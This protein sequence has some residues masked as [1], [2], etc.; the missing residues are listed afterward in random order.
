MERAELVARLDGH[1]WSDIEFKQ[2]Q[3]GVPDSAYETVSAFSN[4]KGGWLVFGVRDGKGGVEIVGVLDADKVQNDFL[5]TL[6][7]GQKLNR[8]VAAEERAIED[9]GKTLL[10][11]HIPEADRRD[12]PVYLGRDIRRSFVRRG[13]G[14][15]RCTQAE[16]ERFLRDAADER[17]DG[18][19]VDLDPARCFDDKSLRWYRKLFEDR[20]PDHDDSLSHLEFLR[21]W[22][23][24][25]EVGGRPAPT[26]AAILL[27]GD[28]PAFRQILPRPIVDWQWSRGD[29]SEELPEERWTDRLVIETNIVK[30][31][32]TLVGRYLRYV[33]KP[34]SVDPETLRREDRPPDYVALRE[35]MINL[36]IHQDYADHMRKPTIRFFDDRTILWNPGDAFAST[37]ELMDPGERD[38]RNPRI[39]AALRRIG[40]SEQAGTG[41]R[42]IFG[43]WRR[44][45]RVPPAVENDKAR[46]AFQL[47]LLKESLLSDEQLKFQ[48]GLG[49]RL[50]EAEARAFAFV[51]REGEASLMQL[52]AAT[53]L[54][55]SDAAAIAERLEIQRLVEPVGGAGRYALAAHLRE[56]AGLPG[57]SGARG[58]REHGDSASRQVDRPTPNLL[59]DQV[60]RPTPDLLT[61]QVDRP[62][63]DLH[64]DQVGRPAPDLHTDQAGRRAPDLP[65]GQVDR[66]PR[67]LHTGQAGRPTPDLHTDQVGRPTTDLHTDQVDRLTELS[68]TQWRIVEHCDAPRRLTEIMAM[69]GV[70]GRNYLR[71]RHLDPLIRAGVVA[72]TNPDKPRASNQ[73]YVVTE[74]GARLLARRVGGGGRR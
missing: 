54:S 40:L 6:R 31:W 68:A 45:G 20:N 52:R 43:T 1:E 18:A 7:S 72:M 71:T 57:R 3:R 64:T 66:P 15:E 8:V 46:K 14:D 38:V 53:G 48:A 42:A 36:L 12:K 23:L 9:G 33:E 70:T 63:T 67:D 55:G 4:T 58:D 30:A 69:L 13:A 74:A 28:E 44:L 62:T 10:V 2:G 35:A 41:I 60:D 26:R 50:D 29:W 25:V 24:V 51:H 73:R 5:S 22:G 39:V 56:G 19:A 16:I 65:T 59:T 37:E 32:K 49:V 21:Y 47:T 11:F 27:F 61:D 34:F 17:H